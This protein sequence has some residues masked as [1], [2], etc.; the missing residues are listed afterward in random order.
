MID[1]A[2]R[3]VAPAEKKA[4]Y[5]EIGRKI[6]ALPEFRD[7]DAKVFDS[8]KKSTV[9]KVKVFDLRGITAYSSEHAQLGE[10]KAA[11]AGWK[12]AI[13]GT[14]ASEL[15]HRNKFS[16]FEGV[17]ENRDLISSYLPV[18]APGSDRIVGVFEIY[19]DVT[20][21]LAQIKSTSDQI[22]KAATDN[23]ARVERAAARN[24]A[25]TETMST[26]SLVVVIALL[27]TLFAT[28]YAIVR[29][30]ERNLTEQEMQHDQAQQQLAQSEKMASL[31]QMV[32]GVAH[33]LN[34][35]LA[36]SHSNVSLVLQQLE[37]IEQ[38]VRV[39]SKF[40]EIVRK[41]PGD[42]VVLNLARVRAQVEACQARPEDVGAMREMLTDVLHGIAQ[43]TELVQHMRNFTR[44]DRAKVSDFD[45][46]KGLR[47]V[48][49]IARSVIPNR[50]RVLEEFGEL[51]EI[52]CNP[53]QLNQVFLNLINNAAQAIKGEGTVTVRSRAAGGRVLVEVE[54]TGSGI[55]PDVLPHIF[56]N[57]F[58]TKPEG[59]GT[60]LGLTI[61]RDIVRS[62]GGDIE[63]ATQ[64]DVGSR[65][66]VWLPVAAQPGLAK[67]A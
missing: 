25:E 16:A 38:P 56:E 31:G 58:S 4:C 34:T 39:A 24:Q 65:F 37:S 41:T 29:R 8:M 3:T 46:N 14:P 10:D 2:G 49:Y 7:I 54:D 11:N 21:F 27:A 43:M 64:L 9:F 15:T 48:A 23:Q 18:L 61:A 6:A 63:V 33:Q 47:T 35:P 13:A 59:E 22:Q 60:G 28:L 62:H 67:A 12:S 5:A 26:T 66:T 17:V 19:S 32:A 51:P 55:A 45:V 52:V 50:V 44:L 57:Y 1:G 42:Q 20:P 36:F 53:S 40:T 30:A